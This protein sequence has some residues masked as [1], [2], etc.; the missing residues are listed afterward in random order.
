VFSANG[1]LQRQK[2]VDDD[3]WFRSQ[4]NFILNNLGP[5]KVILQAASEWPTGTLAQRARQQVWANIV[6]DE[7]PGYK[8]W[9]SPERPTDPQPDHVLDYHPCDAPAVEP[10][11]LRPDT[12][13]QTDCGDTNQLPE[14]SPT[15]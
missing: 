9:N 3:T 7:W 6:R 4:L 10:W 13:V 5:D 11:A 14:R 12:I 8:S 1:C 15:L 2:D